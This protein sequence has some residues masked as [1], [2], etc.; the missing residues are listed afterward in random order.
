MKKKSIVVRF[1]SHNN[2]LLI[3]SS[4]QFLEGVRESEV[5]KQA[6]ALSQIE[7]CDPEYM[8]QVLVN[9][10]VCIKNGNCELPIKNFK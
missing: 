4:C 3:L 9:L 2:F 10:M 1:P 5:I 7:N 6:I 8:M